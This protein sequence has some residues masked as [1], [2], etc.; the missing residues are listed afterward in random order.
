[1]AALIRMTER[2]LT[3][4]ELADLAGMT[5]TCVLKVGLHSPPERARLAAAL[6]RPLGYFDD[7]SSVAR[8]SGAGCAPGK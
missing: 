5:P 3:R 8:R 7:A 1:M 2:G 6:R 4:E